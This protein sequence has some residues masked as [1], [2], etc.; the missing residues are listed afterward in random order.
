MPSSKDKNITK[1]KPTK[2]KEKQKTITTPELTEA[3]NHLSIV[4]QH[5]T[6]RQYRFLIGIVTGIGTVIGATVLAWAVIYILS[7]IV[8]QLD[9]TSIPFL[10]D[11]IQQANLDPNTPTP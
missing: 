3:I 1:D 7:L 9:L 4:I 10:H 5:R 2:N 6:S 11:I 8:A